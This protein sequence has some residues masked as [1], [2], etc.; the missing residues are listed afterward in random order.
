MLVLSLAVL[1]IA[2]PSS[3]AMPGVYQG[4]VIAFL[5]LFGLVNA[6]TAT[7]YAILIWVVMLLCL[8]VLGGCGVVRTDLRLKQLAGQTQ[9]ILGKPNEEKQDQTADPG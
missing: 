6:E 2:P 5:L 7:A 4:V 9:E 8:L 3:P 1:V